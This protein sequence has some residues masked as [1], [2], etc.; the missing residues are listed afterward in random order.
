M[1][2]CQ[3]LPYLADQFPLLVHADVE[4]CGRPFDA[5]A[6]P[7]GVSLNDELG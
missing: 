1:D 4:P 7:K 6:A 3:P 2:G 5:H